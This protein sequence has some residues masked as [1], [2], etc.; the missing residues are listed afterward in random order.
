MGPSFAL[1]AGAA[2]ACLSAARAT[3]AGPAE[4]CPSALADETSLIQVTQVAPSPEVPEKALRRAKCKN[5]EGTKTSLGAHDS[6]HEV[7]EFLGGEYYITEAKR[8]DQ[9]ADPMNAGGDLYKCDVRASGGWGIHQAHCCDTTAK[10][11]LSATRTHMFG[12]G[13][14]GYAGY[15]GCTLIENP[16][17]YCADG[18]QVT[19]DP[20]V[21]NLDGER[22]NLVRTGPHELLRLPRLSDPGSETAPL[23][24]VIGRVEEEQHCLETYVKEVLL[25]GSWLRTIGNISFRTAGGGPHSQG[26][27]QLEV[28]GSAVSVED[29]RD[30]RG[31][32]AHVVEKVTVSSAAH[33]DAEEKGKSIKRLNFLNV[34]MRFPAAALTVEF[35]SRHVP[36]SSVNHLNLKA[37]GLPKPEIMEVGGVLGRDDHTLAATPSDECRQSDL[38]MVIPT[39]Q[40][41]ASEDPDAGGFTASYTADG[42]EV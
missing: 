28:N 20:H 11:P 34:E 38:H 21:T 8:H 31:R 24:Q 15:Y 29:F 42:E 9:I 17:V 6:D 3:A 40:G 22:F 2:L 26:A 4:E 7:F 37:L 1:R 41:A 32:L 19:G 13:G 18:P 36:G 35:L 10:D 27:I 33:P 25:S 16:K 30:S 23:L 12:P 39:P 5:I 14:K